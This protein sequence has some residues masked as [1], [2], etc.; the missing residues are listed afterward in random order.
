MR[1][2]EESGAKSTLKGLANWWFNMIILG[3]VSILAGVAAFTYVHIQSSGFDTSVYL[4]LGVPL[5]IVLAFL[6][7]INGVKNRAPDKFLEILRFIRG[8]QKEQ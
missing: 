2:A 7:W 3:S 6:M 5:V 8:R 4:Y 1:K